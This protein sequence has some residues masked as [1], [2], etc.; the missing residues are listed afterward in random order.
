M[1]ADRIWG[2]TLFN[3]CGS[4]WKHY[5]SIFSPMFS[6][7]HMKAMTVLMKDILTKLIRKLQEPTTEIGVSADV[8]L[9]DMVGKYGM[10]VIGSVAFGIDTNSFNIPS[11]DNK[12]IKCARR[13]LLPDKKMNLMGMG[14][15]FPGFWR[16][17]QYLKIPY[18][19]GDRIMYFYDTIKEIIAARL[20]SK[21]RRN[22]MVDLMIDALKGDL[23]AEEEG[24]EQSADSFSSST[25]RSSITS[26]EE[27]MIVATAIVM[28]AAGAETVTGTMSLTAVELARNP[29]VQERLRQEVDDAYAAKGDAVCLDYGDAQGLE[30]MDMVLNEVIRKDFPN[31]VVRTAIKDYKIPGKDI[32]IPAQTMVMIP[33][34]AI[35]NDPD[36][37]PD[38]KK[39]DPERFSKEN[40]DKIQPYTFLPFGLGPRMCIGMR[41]AQL[42]TKLGMAALLRHFEIL[43]NDNTPKYMDASYGFQEPPK[44]FVLG[45][46]LKRRF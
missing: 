2:K 28:L 8:D 37:F 44:D 18:S 1:Q 39:F 21:D 27:E 11:E 26:D 40:K 38:P 36:H 12:F 31:V 7:G 24:G 22:D 19:K 3:I 9:M 14:M 41:F 29:E 16:L 34:S 20:K 30:Y 5:R 35:H 6:T 4:D 17:V 33:I 45:V 10:D 43:P 42:E 46:K 15:Q 23:K 32:T 13:L 25:D